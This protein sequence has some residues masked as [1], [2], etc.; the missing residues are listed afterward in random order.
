MTEP[1]SKEQI[2]AIRARA[3][4]ASPAPWHTIGFPWAESEDADTWVKSGSNDPHISTFVCDC[5][6]MIEPDDEFEPNDFRPREN[7]EFIACARQDVPALLAH[8]DALE[9]EIG[10]LREAILNLGGDPD[11]AWFWTDR[12]QQLERE[13]Q[14]DIDAGRVEDASDFLAE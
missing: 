14:E 9:A 3:D 11:Q 2:D 6:G 7:A 8:I 1:L 4:A 10:A 12:W 13:A 5:L